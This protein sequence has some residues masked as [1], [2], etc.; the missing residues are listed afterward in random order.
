MPAE[1]AATSWGQQLLCP[2]FNDRV[3]DAI[4]TFRAAYVLKAPE[5]IARPE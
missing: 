2:R 4:R 3:F 5:P 1:V